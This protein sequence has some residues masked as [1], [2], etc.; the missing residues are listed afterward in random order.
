MQ[1]F[2]LLAV[3]TGGFVGAILRFLISGWV[4]KLSPTLF[5]VGTLSVNVIGSFLIGFLALYFESVVAPQQKALVITGMLGA[6][7]T[8][9]T[10]SLE[11]VTMLQGGLW[12]RVT[13]NI[14]LNVFLCVVA[15]L[16]GM[17]LFRRLYG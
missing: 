2:L 12:G 16:L 9:S 15:T 4:Q 14:T 1:P 5:P 10:F 7:T 8:F 13:M 11:T 6:L 3:G 17:M